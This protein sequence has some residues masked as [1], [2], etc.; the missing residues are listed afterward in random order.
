LP[1]RG[2]VSRRRRRAS[3]C[4]VGGIRGGRFMGRREAQ[5]REG[6]S[7]AAGDGPAR[8]REVAARPAPRRRY[9]SRPR[10]A[11]TAAQSERSGDRHS[12]SPHRVP[13]AAL[14]RSCCSSTHAT[15]VPAKPWVGVRRQR[16]MRRRGAQG[17]W[18]RAPARNVF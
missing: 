14:Q 4:A 5:V 12:M 3:P 7:G 10:G 9:R 17:S 2:C 18:P 16:H 6:E 13:P 15:V 1:G 8:S 11:S